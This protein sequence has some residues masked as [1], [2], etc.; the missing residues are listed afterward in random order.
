MT[1]TLMS[2]HAFAAWMLLALSLQVQSAELCLTNEAARLSRL[3]LSQGM[4]G[5]IA[6]S[7]ACHRR[8]LDCQ[9]VDAFG[10][11]LNQHFCSKS[12]CV[13]IRYFDSASIHHRNPLYGADKG[14]EASLLCVEVRDLISSS[15][16]IALG[17]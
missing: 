2:H 6:A 7:E 10:Y 9:F 8:K 5:L 15:V 4:S 13:P 14:K 3:Y 1:N 12:P 16:D 17:N 11:T